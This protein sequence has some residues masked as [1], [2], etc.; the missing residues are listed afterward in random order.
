MDSFVCELNQVAPCKYKMPLRPQLTLAFLS[1][2]SDPQ[3]GVMPT[4]R[5]H[6]VRL[7]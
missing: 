7:M 1:N 5:R 2:I 3:R 6:F 4:L